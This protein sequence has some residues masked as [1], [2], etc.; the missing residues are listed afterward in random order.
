MPD[1]RAQK[2]ISRPIHFGLDSYVLSFS[3]ADRLIGGP[4]ASSKSIEDKDKIND[5][6]FSVMDADTG[7]VLKDIP[8]PNPGKT[9]S[10]DNIA[11][12]LALSP[13]ERFAAVLFHKAAEPPALFP[14]RPAT[15]IA[16]PH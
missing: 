8:G 1:G 6:A 3:R 2:L 14:T 4:A 5:V 12:H 13:D 9:A 7:A 11:V 10:R 16:S 15:G